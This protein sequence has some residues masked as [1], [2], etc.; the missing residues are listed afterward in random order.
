MTSL[1]DLGVTS[2]TYRLP[3]DPLVAEVLN[4]CFGAAHRVRGQFGYFTSSVLGQLAVGLSK[5]LARDDR[6]PPIEFIVS[7]WLSEADA[8]A[9]ESAAADPRR[10]VEEIIAAGVL[11][12]PRSLE[13][14][15]VEEHALRCFAWLL[16]EDL[17]QLE[18]AFVPGGKFHD[19]SWEFADEGYIVEPKRGDAIFVTGSANATR[20][21]LR[22]NSEKMSVFPTWADGAMGHVLPLEQSFSDAFGGYGPALWPVSDALREELIQRWKGD[23]EPTDEDLERAAKRVGDLW[24]IA[25]PVSR[26]ATPAAPTQDGSPHI[27]EWL[28][29][30]STPYEHQEQAVLAWEDERRGVL[31]MAT[32]AGKT[33]TSLVAATRA[34]HATGG[35]TLL[36]I[37]VPFTPLLHQWADDCQRFG[38]KPVLPTI[39][40]GSRSGKFVRIDGLVQ[41][42]AHGVRPFGC[43]LATHHLIADPEFGALVDD[44]ASLGVQTMLIGDEVHRLGAERFVSKP[45]EGF[46]HRLGLSATPVRQYDDDGTDGLFSYFGEVTYEYGL[47]RAIGSCLVEY[48]Y[49]VE[50]VTLNWD[51]VDRFLELTR[52]VGAA[53]RPN[54]SFKENKAYAA[55]VRERRAFLDIASG[56]LP[57]LYAALDRHGLDPIHHT[58]IYSSARDSSQIEAVQELLD[59]RGISNERITY[60]ET[61][62][63]KKVQDTIHRF[64]SGDVAVLNAMK[65]LDEGF[66]I[67]EIATAFLLSSTGTEREWTQRRGRVL[68]M[69]PGKEKATIVD[70]LVLPPRDAQHPPAVVRYIEGELK[71]VEAFARHSANKFEPHGGYSV[72]SNLLVE[73]W[74]ETR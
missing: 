68:R 27:P 14:D 9:V 60:K 4:P 56:K 71:R 7:P 3:Q 1:R 48:D 17:L 58:L 54:A 21:A 64:R 33:W 69:A 42:L 72:I 23:H 65:V 35:P 10:A 25:D 8:A 46:R 12:E 44:A 61:P 26:I 16:A 29:W 67:P 11:R 13:L 37:G 18:I 6:P 51:E 63:V 34:H 53:Y 70:F 49:Y 43:V 47:D 45:P 62:D 31:E 24:L 20:Q 39:D 28:N 50:P 73:R 36:V 74:G 19:K 38:M 32:G 59:E 30:R 57:A 52:K 22:T 15:R 40:A 2:R 55:A 66:N 5:F 41:D